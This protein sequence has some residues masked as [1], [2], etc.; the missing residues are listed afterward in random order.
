[1][2]KLVLMGSGETAPSLVGV[3]RQLLAGLS[4]ARCVWLDTPYGFQENADILSAKTAEFFQQ[5]FNQK[6]ALA[7]Y[8]HSGQPEVELQLCYR[9]LRNANYLFTGP[10]SPSYAQL[11]W[12]LSEIPLIFQEKLKQDG[13][14]VIFASAAA[15]AVGALCLPVYEIY[16]VGNEPHWLPGLEI[17]PALGYPAV[18]LPHFNNTVGGNHDTRFCYLGERRLR[19]LENQLEPHLWIWGVD[20]HTAV[21]LDLAADRFEVHGKGGFT[22]R[23]EAQV[24]FFDSGYRGSLQELRQPVP[25]QSVGEETVEVAATTTQGLVTELARPLAQRFEMSL[26]AGDGLGAAQALLEYEQLL[27]D[28]SGDSDVHHWGIAR[29]QFRNLLAQIGESAQKG[30]QDPRKPIEPFVEVL[31][32]M[33]N[34]ARAER[35]FQRADQI[36]QILQAAG[37]EVQDT[38]EGAR[39]SLRPEAYAL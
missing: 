2:S 17:L 1:M 36:R 13:N 18:V 27:V 7:S 5:S 38:P 11:H 34:E 14:V 19:V 37:V 8:R 22:L 39:W 4:P 31:L 21:I 28:W 9:S 32:K 12:S 10:G 24:S 26:H 20:E 30:L 35:Q 16:K 25:G 3:H 33:R 29:S 15:C 6:L 23:R